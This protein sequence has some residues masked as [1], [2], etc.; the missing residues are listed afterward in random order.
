MLG[1]FGKASIGTNK[2]KMDY[3]TDW[4]AGTSLMLD[5]NEYY[6]AENY[7]QLADSPILIGELTNAKH[8]RK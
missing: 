1:Y 5:E 4:T 2:I 8:N 6:T 3:S 7:D